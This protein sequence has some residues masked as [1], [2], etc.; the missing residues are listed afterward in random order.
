MPVLSRIRSGLIDTGLCTLSAVYCRRLRRYPDLQDL[1]D[2]LGPRG[3]GE[4][5]TGVSSA[6]YVM[7][8]EAIKV[9]QPSY[10][11]ELGAG[12]SS[13]AIVLALK[14]SGHFTAIEESPRWIA[15]HRR[16]IPAHLLPR[17]D[18]IQRDVAV[19][20]IEGKLC[21][22]YRDLP[23]RPYDFVHV[24]G[25][26]LRDHGADCSC[27]VVDLLPLLAARCFITFDGREVSARFAKPHLERAGFTLRRHPF[28]LAYQFERH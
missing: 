3:G 23:A 28:T 14:G 12:R 13:A 25:P 9:R 21:A 2:A 16:I 8:Y 27:D 7:L 22:F 18:L 10:V 24:D 26:T 4:N 19:R 20:T 15:D 6:D 5:S 11:L 1:L 17:V